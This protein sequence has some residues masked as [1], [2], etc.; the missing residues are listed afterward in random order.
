MVQICLTRGSPYSTMKSHVPVMEKT[1]SK[2]DG[3]YTVVGV[4]SSCGD[5][6]CAGAKE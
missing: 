1:F 2:R 3:I 4:L 6:A 5:C